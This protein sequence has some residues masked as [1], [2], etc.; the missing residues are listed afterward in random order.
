MRSQFPKPFENKDLWGGKTYLQRKQSCIQPS[1]QPFICSILLLR[2]R[3]TSSLS[4]NILV[5]NGRFGG[6]FSPYGHGA[7]E[8]LVFLFDELGEE[9]DSGVGGGGKGAE[10]GC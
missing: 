2:R 9:A 7:L 6:V 4:V 3:E 10:H 1:R 8:L 5:N